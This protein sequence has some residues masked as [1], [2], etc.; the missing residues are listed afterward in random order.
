MVL[1]APPHRADRLAADRS[2]LF[3]LSRLTGSAYS[4]SFSPPGTGSARTV[5]LPQPGAPRLSG[6]REQI[7]ITSAGAGQMNAIRMVA[8]ATL[9]YGKP[10]V[11]DHGHRPERLMRS[12]KSNEHLQPPCRCSRQLSSGYR[13][14]PRHRRVRVTF[15]V[16][17]PARLK[18]NRATGGC[19]TI[20]FRPASAQC[21]GPA[22]SARPEPNPLTRRIGNVSS[23]P[24]GDRWPGGS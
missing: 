12:A 1:P 6:L 2:V 9:G 19:T 11:P 21:P 16:T 13:S 4:N 17:R 20:S 23:L 14:P 22:P 10:D 18:Q 5:S 3:G 8:S 7:A 15:P 24:R